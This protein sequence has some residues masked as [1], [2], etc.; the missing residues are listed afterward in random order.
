MQFILAMLLGLLLQA[1][2]TTIR[3]TVQSAEEGAAIVDVLVRFADESGSITGLC[4]TDAHG[5]CGMVLDGEIT[6]KEVVRGAL[7]I[8]RDLGTRSVIFFGDERQIEVVVELDRFG[9]VTVPGHEPLP[10]PDS[11]TESPT[12]LPTAVPTETPSD[13]PVVVFEPR[14]EATDETPATIVI[15][16][17]AA[18]DEA[19]AERPT[20]PTPAVIAERQPSSMWPIILLGIAL[21]LLIVIGIPV[22]VTLWRQKNG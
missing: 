12:P 14:A 21:G 22:G 11:F 9:R 18:E 15:I 1:E 5:D 6:D 19:E 16:P 8:G 20:E 7:F 10:T 4:T 2:P 13:S 3:I 17:A